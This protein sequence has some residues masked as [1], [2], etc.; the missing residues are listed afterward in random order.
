MGSNVQ[1]GCE[2]YRISVDDFMHCGS[3]SRYAE[4]MSLSRRDSLL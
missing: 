1:F 2:F 3:F 4:F